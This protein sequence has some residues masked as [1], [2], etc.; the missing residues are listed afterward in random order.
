VSASGLEMLGII[1]KNSTAHP[2]EEQ[3]F[4]FCV[5]IKLMEALLHVQSLFRT[6]LTVLTA[7]DGSSLS[8]TS[9]TV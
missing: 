4:Y 2:A 3:H 5:L 8:V 1:S 7:G 6:G 9:Q